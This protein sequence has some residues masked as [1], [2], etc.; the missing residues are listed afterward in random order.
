M[1]M[2][3]ETANSQRMV[4]PGYLWEVQLHLHPLSP[5]AMFGALVACLLSARGDTSL[6]A[7]CPKPEL[8]DIEGS[9]AMP[10]LLLLAFLVKIWE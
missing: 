9:A 4:T 5:S 3:F 10:R 1:A 6:L 2:H 8:E 7:I